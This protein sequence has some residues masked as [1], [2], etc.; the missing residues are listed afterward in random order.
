MLLDAGK[1]RR[2]GCRSWSR[3]WISRRRPTSCAEPFPPIRQANKEFAAK[4]EA[5]LALAPAMAEPGVAQARSSR[6]KR[7]T[8]DVRRDVS[9][10]RAEDAGVE[11]DA[12]IPCHKSLTSFLFGREW[13]TAS[14]WQ[15][16]Y[17]H[18]P[19]VRRLAAGLGHRAR[20]RGAAG[21]LGGDLCQRDR[22]RRRRRTSS[23]RTSSSSPRFRRSCSASSASRCSVR[24]CAG[25]RRCP[26]LSLVPGLSDERAA[27][28]ADRRLPARAHGC[29]DDLLARRGRAEQRAQ[30]FQGSLLRAG[31][32][33]LSDHRAHPRARFALRHH[34]RDP[35]RLRAGHRRDHG[36]A[37]L[38]GQPH[39][40]SRFH[41][42]ASAP[43]SSRCIP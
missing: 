15:D 17:G 31:R 37:A 9:R 30:A 16:W 11:H 12:P 29:A 35:A 2:G 32:E 41:A 23:S 5:A 39:R 24:R 13:L 34:L 14:F 22:R 20:H 38:R 27:E 10:D 36:R 3:R 8:Q 28:L 19:A 43:S 7:Q 33:S 6:V 18:R 1:T 25:S 21:R 4:L 42:R 40:H 26:W